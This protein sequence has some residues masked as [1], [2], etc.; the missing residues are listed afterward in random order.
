MRY[1]EVTVP[2]IVNDERDGF[3]KYCVLGIGMLHFFRL[4]RLLCLVQYGF[5]AFVQSA[6]GTRIVWWRIVL[7]EPQQFDAEPRRWHEVIR[8]I[9]EITIT[10]RHDLL[11]RRKKAD[12]DQNWGTRFKDSYPRQTRDSESNAALVLV[13]ILL[14]QGVD[15]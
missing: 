12:Q 2:V 13:R 6:P 8:V 7:Q 4:G 11:K 9:L 15:E 5:Q 3:E 14:D 1:F 10:C